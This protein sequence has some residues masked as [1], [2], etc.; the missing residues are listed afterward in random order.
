MHRGFPL[1]L[2]G[3]IRDI[4]DRKMAE[5]KIQ[6]QINEYQKLTNEYQTQNKALQKSFNEVKKINQELEIARAKAEESD[7]LKSAFLANMSHE[8][9]TPMNGILG[10]AELLEE[11][12]LTG[13]MQKHYVSVIQQSGQR[14]LKYN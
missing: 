4:T 9:R 5:V 6:Q 11:P 7:R 12:A 3:T 2:I 14:M 13:E 1:K 8:I 10:F